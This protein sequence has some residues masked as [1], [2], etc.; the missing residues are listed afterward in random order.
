MTRLTFQGGMFA[1][2]GGILGEGPLYVSGALPNK[3]SDKSLSFKNTLPFILLYLCNTC[4]FS[5]TTQSVSKRI[6]RK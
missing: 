5:I 4:A 6:Y 3:N 1:G 2:F